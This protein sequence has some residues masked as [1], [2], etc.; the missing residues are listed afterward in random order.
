MTW[1]RED[2]EELT[3]EDCWDLLGPAGTG[4]LAVVVD[5]EPEIFPVN[6][7][8]DEGTVVLRSGK[9][10]KTAGALS[11]ASVAFEVDGRDA[12]AGR[13][14]SV[15]LK[16]HAQ[17]VP[18]GHELMNALELPLFP[19]QAGRKD[20]FLRILPAAVTGRRFSVLEPEAWDSTAAPGR[21]T[22]GGS[23]RWLATDPGEP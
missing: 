9:G 18:P 16:G 4:R 14:W 11:G 12:S 2:V 22:P 20:T 3:A 1:Y 19:W 17:D 6:Y 7:A 8:V 23:A 5:G 10:T 21:R 13:A 15:V